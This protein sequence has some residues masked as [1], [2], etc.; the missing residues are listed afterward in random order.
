[1][2]AP[3][4]PI[5]QPNLVPVRL[6]GSRRAYFMTRVQGFGPPRDIWPGLDRFAGVMLG[7]TILLLVSLIRWPTEARLAAEARAGH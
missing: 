5:S 4:E 7:L 6:I 1:M 2:Q 3:H